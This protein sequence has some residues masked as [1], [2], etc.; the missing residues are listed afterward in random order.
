MI[1][2][3]SVVTAVIAPAHMRSTEYPGTEFGMPASRDAVRP[4]VMPWSPICVV[5]ATAT[6]SMR[7]G[8]RFGL[9][10]SSSRNT[11]TTRSSARVSAK[12]LPALPNGVRTPSTNTTS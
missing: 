2:E 3:L 11:L 9:R 7:S 1:A 6:S 5:A 10:R 12:A 4:M 8:E